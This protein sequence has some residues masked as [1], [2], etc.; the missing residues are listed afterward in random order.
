MFEMHDEDLNEDDL[1]K[2]LELV[3]RHTGV[4][5]A[6]SKKVL[7][8]SR[9]RARLVVHQLKG[10]PEY[11]S[12]V[13]SDPAELSRFIDLVTTHET[14]F[15]RTQG[16]WE[17]FSKE[18]LPQFFKRSGSTP[19]K[20][21]SAACSTGEEPYTL[22]MYCENFAKSHT[23]FHY[24][25][26]ASDISNDV[27]S[28][29]KAARYQGRSLEALK[30]A[31]PSFVDAYMTAIDAEVMEVVPV[32]RSKITFIQKNL[33]QPKLGSSTFDLVLLRNVL[34]YFDASDQEKVIETIRGSLHRDGIL[35]IGESESLSPL[36]TQMEF[37]KPLVYASKKAG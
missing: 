16:V 20:I 2:A 1:K 37:I 26:L 35:V 18:F 10:W 13:E 21:W 17:Y 34:I 22:A 14:Y 32:I 3:Y 4:R 27:L 29:A 19:L 25:V 31:N 9:L 23:D 28:F 6:T 36:K 30:K 7:L 33:F 11:W 8:R 15:H 5:M 24:S 12:V